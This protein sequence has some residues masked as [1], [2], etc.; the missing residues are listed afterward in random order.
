MPTPRET[1]T[2]L[3]FAFDIVRSNLTDRPDG[4]MFIGVTRVTVFVRI[5][6]IIIYLFIFF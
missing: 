2:Y 6:I 3:L 1:Y 5:V 4:Q